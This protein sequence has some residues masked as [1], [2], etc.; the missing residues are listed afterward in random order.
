MLPRNVS[1]S[2]FEAN[3]SVSLETLQTRAVQRRAGK[4]G[5]EVAFVQPQDEVQV[6][7]RPFWVEFEQWIG[8]R[9]RAVLIWAGENAPVAA[10]KP[11]ADFRGELGGNS[12]F[13]LYGEVADTF[14]RVEV[15]IRP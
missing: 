14:I 11:V 10:E 2:V 12:A 7:H 3:S 5:L 6:E 9:G 13:V 1:S 8:Y 15:S 4:A